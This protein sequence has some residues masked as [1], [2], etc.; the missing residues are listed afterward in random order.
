[1]T[2]FDYDPGIHKPSHENRGLDSRRALPPPT[3]AQIRRWLKAQKTKSIGDIVT[4]FQSH[5]LAL[6]PLREPGAINWWASLPEKTAR[7]LIENTRREL[8]QLDQMLLDLRDM[9]ERLQTAKCPPTSPFAGLPTIRLVDGKIIEKRLEQTIEELLT[10]K[11]HYEVM[12]TSPITLKAQ[13]LSK[14]AELTLV[15]KQVR[16]R[17]RR[18]ARN[19]RYQTHLHEK[20]GKPYRPRTRPPAVQRHPKSI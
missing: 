8:K 17:N 14:R 2:N 6:I 16:S 19:R 1:M 11:A 18:A 3:P 12:I 15:A 13:I 20:N 7:D 10:V 5:P 9:I 4:D